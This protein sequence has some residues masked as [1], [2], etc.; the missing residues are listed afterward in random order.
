MGINLAIIR[1]YLDYSPIISDDVYLAETAVVIGRVEIDKDSNIWDGV[2]IRG[3]IN[4]VKIGKGVSIQE[5]T[6]VHEGYFEGEDTVIGDYSLIGHG[7]IIHGCKIDNNCLIGMGAIIMNKTVIR[8]G[9]IVAAGS[10]VP[11]GKEYPPNSLIMGSP[12]KA[13]REVNAAD[14]ESIKYGVNRYIEVS[15]EY[16]QNQHS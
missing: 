14:A 1:K 15:K 2:V 3:D 9:S 11:E 13:I 12:A 4:P 8:E 16:M 6:V 10:L 7:C 5:N